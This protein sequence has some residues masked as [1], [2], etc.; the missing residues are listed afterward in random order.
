MH[1]LAFPTANN[2]E[3]TNS[4]K[5]QVQKILPK[6][7]FAR[8]VSVLLGGT[9]SAQMLLVLASPL[10]TRLYSPEDFGLLAVYASLLAMIGVI[11][12]LR[13]ELA[14]PLPEDE[15]EAANVAALSL[16]IAFVIAMLSALIVVAF[17]ESI[18][19][20]LGLPVLAGCLWLIPIGV[21]L[22]GAYT[23]FSYWSIRKKSF[24]VIAGTR[25]RQAL[26]TILIQLTAFKLGGTALLLGQ[27]A[28]QS[29]GTVRLA[30]LALLMPAFNHLT[31]RGIWS[32]ARR[33]RRFPFFSTWA[34]LLN[35][36]G[37]QLLPLLLTTFFSSVA[38]GFYALAYRVLTL[39]MSLVGSAI[40]SVYFSGAAA[41]HRDKDL[42]NRTQKLLNIL[43]QIAVPPAAVIALTGPQFFSWFFGNQWL[44]AGQIAQWM[45]P[46]LVLQ[47]CTGPLIIVFEAVEKQHIGMMMQGQL[48]LVRAIMLI[49]GILNKNIIL[50]IFLFSLGSSISYMMFMHMILRTVGLSFRIFLY[51]LYK[52]I[53]IT[54]FLIS[55]ILF[56][57]FNPSLSHMLFY[58]LLLTLVFIF[59]RYLYI[60]YY[61]ET[62]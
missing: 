52:S 3:K 17:G 61:F 30:R 47:F 53:I 38:T 15:Q 26:A 18:A 21:L 27:V 39:P 45:T 59:F 35:T 29:I 8:G 23:V 2:L 4:L 11:A 20:S 5:H 62:I 19:Q 50:T 34:G 51:S 28:G 7:P 37:T 25:L 49:I 56:L 57:T 9:V 32:V 54:F 46:W 40:Q 55:P 41:A 1:R 44:E 14:I 12:C 24:N 31:L 58:A 22:K 60:Y 16:L 10:L 33:Y 48:F 42:G 13:Y 6:S 36:G 43:V